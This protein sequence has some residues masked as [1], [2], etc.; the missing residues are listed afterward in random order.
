MI[1]QHMS[2]RLGCD[3]EEVSA[4]LP[5]PGCI[6]REPQIGFVDQG[7]SL[8]RMARILL[9][10]IPLGHLV[11]LRVNHRHQLFE[12]GMIPIAPFEQLRD[13]MSRRRHDRPCLESE[14]VYHRRP[15]NSRPALVSPIPS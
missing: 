10:H 2:H 4:I 14:Q 6:T 1:H 11:Q 8:E 5:M 3:S 13:Q 15:A 7:S 9:A 12:R